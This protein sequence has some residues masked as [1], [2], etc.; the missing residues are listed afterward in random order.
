MPD[1]DARDLGTLVRAMLGSVRGYWV[2]AESYQKFLYFI[3]ALLL[4]SAVFH[5]GVLIATGGSLEGPVSWR[6]PILFGEAFGLTA[7]SVAWVMTFLPRYRIRGWLLAG[8]LGVAN[9]G[10]VFWV[11]M[12]QWRGVPSHFNLAT[13]FDAAAFTAAGGLIFFT[14]TVITIVTLWTFL[15]LQAPRSFA[16]AI[17]AGMVLLIFSQLVF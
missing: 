12:Q 8:T 4:A 14:A 16:W 9:F 5:T 11:S 17:R 2:R 13:P 1:R 10:E 7:L 15:S 3:G 6:K